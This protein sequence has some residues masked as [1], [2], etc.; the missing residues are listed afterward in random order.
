MGVLRVSEELQLNLELELFRAVI[1]A[2]LNDTENVELL[3]AGW[4][5]VVGE[6]LPHVF[7]GDLPLRSLGSSPPPSLRDARH[8]ALTKSIGVAEH[9]AWHFSGGRE[10][11]PGSR[12]YR[13]DLFSEGG[14]PYSSQIEKLF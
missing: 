9:F 8:R 3:V 5:P 11:S 7:L 1:E 6:P 13:G 4:S 10:L 2:E 12:S 14:I